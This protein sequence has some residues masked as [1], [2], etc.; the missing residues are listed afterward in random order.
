MNSTTA[1]RAG[2]IRVRLYFWTRRVR[3]DRHPGVE[4]IVATSDV[5]RHR[6]PCV[7]EPHVRSSSAQHCLEAVVEDLQTLVID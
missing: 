4:A 1:R 3:R 6:E 5:R 2:L 7:S